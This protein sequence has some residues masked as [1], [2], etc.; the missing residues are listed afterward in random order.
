MRDYDNTWYCGN[1]GEPSSYQGHT[2][3]NEDKTDVVFYCKPKNKKE[4][5]EEDNESNRIK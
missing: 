3:L 1:C 2:R 4:N 5:K